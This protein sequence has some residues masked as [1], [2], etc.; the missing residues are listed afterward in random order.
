MMMKKRHAESHTA[1][2]DSSQRGLLRNARRQR[3][4]TVRIL[5]VQK[6][7][8]LKRKTE[9]LLREKSTQSPRIKMK[10]SPM[11]QVF[12]AARKRFDAAFEF[13]SG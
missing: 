3:I 6:F 8:T 4:S 1:A 9:L 10:E 7:E 11:R 12:S 5:S 2:G 13:K